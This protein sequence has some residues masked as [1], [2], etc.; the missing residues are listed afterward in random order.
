MV[1]QAPCWHA[2]D[3]APLNSN[4]FNV[5]SYCTKRKRAKGGATM[6]FRVE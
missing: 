3:T 1:S 5:C 2:I 4:A 6:S